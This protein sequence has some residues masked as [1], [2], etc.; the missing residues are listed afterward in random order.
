M[1]LRAPISEDVNISER[2]GNRQVTNTRK[3]ERNY[4]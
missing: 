1:K 4:L 2:Y 3:K